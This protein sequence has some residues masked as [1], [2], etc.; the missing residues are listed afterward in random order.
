[1]ALALDD[2]ETKNQF[3]GSAELQGSSPAKRIDRPLGF[4]LIEW[5]PTGY[6]KK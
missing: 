1:L 5:R 3:D 4:Y 6:G 2:G